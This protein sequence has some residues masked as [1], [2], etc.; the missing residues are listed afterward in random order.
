MFD[1][2]IGCQNI[3]PLTSIKDGWLWFDKLVFNLSTEM[4]SVPCDLFF[5]SLDVFIPFSYVTL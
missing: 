4:N 2:E 1:L 5:R 3:G